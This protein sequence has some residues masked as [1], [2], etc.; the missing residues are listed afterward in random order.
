MP[1]SNRETITAKVAEIAERAAAPEGIEVVETLLLGGG[2]Q[3]VL[4]IFIDKPAGVTHADCE[5]M[6]R[7]VGTILDIEEVIPGGRYTLEISSP[8]VERPLKKPADYERFVGQKAKIVLREP[9]EN[10]SSWIG[11]L[12]GYSDGQI[13]LDPG[14]GNTVS[15]PLSQVQKANLKFEW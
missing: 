11:V 2:N 3:R 15:I 9:V 5:F 1:E 12:A 6:S 7:Q 8:G 14:E 13:T 4:R 10:K